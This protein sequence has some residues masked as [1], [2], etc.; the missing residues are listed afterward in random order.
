[1]ATV[2]AVARENGAVM[3]SLA[4]AGIAVFPADDDYSA[5]W[6]AL[7]S[8]LRAGA[9]PDRL[10][11]PMLRAAFVMVF[12]VCVHSLL[13][14]PLW[15]AYFLLPTAFAFGLCLAGPGPTAAAVEGRTARDATRPLVVASMLLMI[16]GLA[17]VYDYT[18]VVVI[19]APPE[20]APP[21]AQRIADGRRSWFFAHHADYAAATNAPRPAEA[22][23]SFLVASHY[24]LDT[25]LMISW[26]NALNDAGDTD[27]AR[28]VAQRLR[29]FRNEG[30]DAFFAPCAEPAQ[31]GAALPFQC[32]APQ[33]HYDFQD[34]R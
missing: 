19:F 20:G 10:Q 1:M 3:A 16:G 22:M 24:L 5:L 27:H 17:S 6:R 31:S 18:R 9:A 30:A 23:R 11:A 12:M 33:R 8:A 21:L 28:Y 25:R 2:Q 4:V 15:Y 7:M 32:E 29:E 13:E 34:F 14:Y 26:A